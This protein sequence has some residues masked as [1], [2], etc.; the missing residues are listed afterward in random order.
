[1]K[2]SG[3]GQGGWS[4]NTEKTLNATELCTQKWL[5]WS[6]SVRS[7]LLF[8]H[9]KTGRLSSLHADRYPHRR[10]LTTQSKRSLCG[11]GTR[12]RGR[13]WNREGGPHAA[14]PSSWKRARSQR[15]LQLPA[16]PAASGWQ[17]GGAQEETWVAGP[18]AGDSEPAGLLR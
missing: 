15:R 7:S 17:D 3:D 12:A 8:A 11:E 10:R 13:G 16:A 1:M 6:A 9:W 4:Q 2:H 18:G 5:E 14:P